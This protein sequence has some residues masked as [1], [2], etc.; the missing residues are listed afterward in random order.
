[1]YYV[2]TEIQKL[3]LAK[4]KNTLEKKKFSKT[5]D[6]INLV[7]YF[8]KFDLLSQNNHWSFTNEK[9]MSSILRLYDITYIVTQSIYCTISKKQ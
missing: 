9:Y 5:V 3:K 4:K 8:E 2:T 1:M 7:K 6:K